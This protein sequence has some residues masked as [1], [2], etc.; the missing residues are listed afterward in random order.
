MIIDINTIQKLYLVND[1]VGW[2]I[3]V[4]KTSQ[5]GNNFFKHIMLWLFC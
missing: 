3:C 5:L 2:H 4:I 1:V